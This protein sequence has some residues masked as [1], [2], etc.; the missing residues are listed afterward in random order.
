LR[1]GGT[2]FQETCCYEEE[3][4]RHSD[5][6]QAQASKCPEGLFSGVFRAVCENPR[7]ALDFSSEIVSYV[8]DKDRPSARRAGP[9]GALRARYVLF[10]GPRGS[11]RQETETMKMRI[12]HRLVCSIA[13][14][15]LLC[16]ASEGIVL[17]VGSGGHVA[18]ESAFHDHHNSCGRENLG[19]AGEQ[20]EDADSH[21]HSRGCRPC[22]DIPVWMGLP[23]ENLSAAKAKVI[24]QAGACSAES[25]AILQ[26]K[27]ISLAHSLPDYLPGPFF[28]PLR[29]IVLLA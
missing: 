11:A 13:C 5:R 1:C 27:F 2:G 23:Q 8:A 14:L 19:T 24:S 7:E 28:R 26:A 3:T 4:H 20:A 17:C 10:P 12:S 16:N 6:S 18:L 22:V 9:G 21:V 25:E 29:T 15:L